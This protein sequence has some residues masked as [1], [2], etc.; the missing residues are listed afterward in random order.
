MSRRNTT[1]HSGGE[2]DAS[3]ALESCEFSNNAFERLSPGYARIYKNYEGD[4]FVLIATK[5]KLW[6]QTL[7]HFS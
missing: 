7:Q 5:Y 3:L 1:K 6:G 2:G 4:R